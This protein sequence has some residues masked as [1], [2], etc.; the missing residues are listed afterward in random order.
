MIEFAVFVG[1]FVTAVFGG[2]WAGRTLHN[3]RVVRK[4]GGGE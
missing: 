4:W 3:R 1:I 2:L